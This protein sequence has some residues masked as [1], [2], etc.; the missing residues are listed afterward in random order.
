MVH[1]IR[2]TKG[3]KPPKPTTDRTE[4]DLAIRHGI[5]IYKMHGDINSEIAKLYEKDKLVVVRTI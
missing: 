5:V 1:K 4:T 3:V 2:K